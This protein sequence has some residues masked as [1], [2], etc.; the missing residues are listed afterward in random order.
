[1]IISSTTQQQT[2]DGNLSAATLPSS[3]PLIQHQ[4][5]TARTMSSA[6]HLAP[7]VAAVLKDKTVEELVQK[8]EQ[9]ERALQRM[10]KVE[11]T[12]PQGTPVYAEGQFDQGNYDDGNTSDAI[13]EWLVDMTRKEGVQWP[14]RG[15]RNLELRLGGVV[16]FTTNPEHDQKVLLSLDGDPVI[17]I[18]ADDDTRLFLVISGCEESE[19]EAMLELNEEVSNLSAEVALESLDT[20]PD[21]CIVHIGILEFNLK[22]YQS[23]VDTMPQ[24]KE[25]KERLQR[26]HDRQSLLQRVKEV[27]P[28][29][30]A[31][32]CS[33][34][35]VQLISESLNVKRISEEADLILPTL[36]KV[37]ALHEKMDWFSQ[38][39]LE[40]E[41][42]N[43][44]RDCGLGNE[45]AEN[46]RQCLERFVAELQQL[47]RRHE[48]RES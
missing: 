42:S 16:Q 18:N 11:I 41:I 29:L 33:H 6:S 24:S 10:Y 21:S 35:Q 17:W 3:S 36:A 46:R 37:Y 39:Q 48:S 4:H 13:N 47:K 32:T 27:A 28:E 7:F 40:G 34:I 1:M 26:H 44:A 20:L 14:L 38:V 43:L 23:L 8:V 45:K 31:M 30:N 22:K 12:G 2:L 25:Q 5:K 9:Q 19:W 15:L